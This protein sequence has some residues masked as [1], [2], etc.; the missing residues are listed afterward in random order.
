[1]RISVSFLWPSLSALSLTPTW[2]GRP[3]CMEHTRPPGTEG[4]TACPHVCLRLKYSPGSTES[5]NRAVI[6]TTW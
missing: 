3:C 2:P 4:M 5:H 6:A 1:M